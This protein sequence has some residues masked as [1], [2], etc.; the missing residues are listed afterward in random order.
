[1]YSVEIDIEAAPD[2]EALPTAA[3][4]TYAELIV[5]LEVAPLTGR[6]LSPTKPSAN[7]RSHTFGPHGEGL[8][9]Y[10]V[11]DDQRRVIVLRVMWL[12]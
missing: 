11:L 8:V 9:I 10:Y 3:L 5:T 6:L 2:V 1:M 4:A 12:V 7:M